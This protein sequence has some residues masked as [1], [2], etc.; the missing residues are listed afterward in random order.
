MSNRKSSPKF[1]RAAEIRAASFDE[2]DNSIEVVWTTGAAV[3]RRDWQSGE[4]Y[5]EVLEVTPAAVRLDR[6]N[7]GAPLLDTHDDWSLRSVIGS[8][9]PGSA[10]IEGGKG[11]AR[12]RLSDADGDADVVSKIRTG[13]IRNVSVGYAIHKAVKTARDDQDD[14]WRVV[15]WEPLEIS[16]VP[17]PADAGSQFRAAGDEMPEVE[18]V[19]A[20]RTDPGTPADSTRIDAIAELALRAGL[21]DLGQAHIKAGTSVADFRSVLLTALVE[22]EAPTIDTRIPSRVGTEHN[23]KRAAAMTA[24]LLHRSDPAAFPLQNGGE[25][26]RGQDL[27]GMARESLELRGEKTRG[28]THEEIVAR[29]FEQRSG[30]GSTSDFPVV[31]GNVA[32]TTLRAAYEAAPQTFRPFTRQVEVPDF[33]DVV[34]VQLSEGPAFEKVNE[35]GEYKRGSLSEA[36]EKYRIYSYGKIVALTRQAVINDNF[37]AFGRLPAEFGKQAAQLESDLVWAQILGNPV[38]GDG[39]ALFHSSRGNIAG[40][41]VALSSP[42][43]LAAILAASTAMAV[44]KGL[45]GKTVLNLRPSMLITSEASRHLAEQ[46]VEAGARASTSAEAVPQRVRNL[47]II[48]D[49]RVDNGIARPDVGVNVAG[50]ET[51]WWLAS[52]P[53]WL[54]TIELAYLAGA[55]GVSVESRVGFDVDGIEFKASLDVGA[56]AIDWRG[57]HRGN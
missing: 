35:H 7:A 12:V 41:L 24:A 20:E 18:F 51:G 28:S 8:V 9:V 31:L 22:R 37:D 13:I 47:Q 27:V 15:D 50:G 26:Y 44:R 57:F 36:S 17:V 14:E 25:E 54:D 43:A 48:S 2:G 11:L 49:P 21:V 23:E 56:K 55:P 30:Y 53:G 5:S 39:T 42:S 46:I 3:R 29:A 38:M 10:R 6:L 4:P 16:A 33:K 52:A 34:R 1:A 32:N 19:E 40:S 45:D